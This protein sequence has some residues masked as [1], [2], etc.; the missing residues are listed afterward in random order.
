MLGEKPSSLTFIYTLFK[1]FLEVIPYLPTSLLSIHFLYRRE[2]LLGGT[3]EFSLSKS[4]T[5]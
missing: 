1:K 3:I 4:S 5:C 2:Y